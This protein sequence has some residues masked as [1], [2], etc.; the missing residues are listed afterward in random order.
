MDAYK[1]TIKGIHGA[2]YAQYK[3][4]T[5]VL[6]INELDEKPDLSFTLNHPESWNVKAPGVLKVQKLI[7]RT[8]ADKVAMF[9]MV[10]HQRK[11]LTYR[12]LAEE[13]RNISHV[14]VNK[15]L[16][17][18]YFN[19][20]Q[21]PLTGTK[22]ITDYIRHYNTVRDLAINGKPEKSR[23]PDVYDREFERGLEGETLSAYWQ[24]LIKCGWKKTDGVWMKANY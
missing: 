17:D 11:N 6:F 7:P 15:E 12:P 23:F 3:N 18:V 4:Q 24:H 1:I 2:A 13:K 9:C 10:Y 16:L 21:Y 19:H 22:T 20:N 8:A 5:L 14:T